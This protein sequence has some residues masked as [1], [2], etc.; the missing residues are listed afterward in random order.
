MEIDSE[1]QEAPKDKGIDLSSPV[2]HP[3]DYL[4]ESVE[5]IESVNLPRDVVVTRKRPTW[6]HETL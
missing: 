1:E 2:V 5:P 4:E 6:L 3:L